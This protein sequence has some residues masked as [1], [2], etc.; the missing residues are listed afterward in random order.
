MGQRLF[1]AVR[2]SFRRLQRSTEAKNSKSFRSVL[3][4]A[5]KRKWILEGVFRNR[6][7]GNRPS[8]GGKILLWQISR[9]FCLELCNGFLPDRRSMERRRY[10]SITMLRLELQTKVRSPTIA[11]YPA[12]PDT[13]FQVFLLKFTSFSCLSDRG[14]RGFTSAWKTLSFT[15]SLRTP[16]VFTNTIHRRGVP[17]VTSV[18]GRLPV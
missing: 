12:Y 3:Q 1:R 9:R 13:Y 8:N 17:I 16:P 11:W 10:T 4:T 5:Y 2:Y 6:R 7:Q 14:I 15:P 18:H